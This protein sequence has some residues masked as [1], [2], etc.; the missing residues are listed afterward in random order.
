M[1][2]NLVAY[3]GFHFF[4]ACTEVNE[5]LAMKYL[6]KTD[7]IF[8]KFWKK[9]LRRLLTTHIQMRRYVEVRKIPERD[10]YHTYWRLHLPMLL[11]T[12][13]K[14]FFTEKYEYQ[15]YICRWKNCKKIILTCCSCSLG[16]W[17]YKGH[18]P[19]CVLEKVTGDNVTS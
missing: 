9:M 8:M 4:I 6:L 10:K 7:D 2:S 5:Y 16:T 15:K 17:L 1:G 12:I 11:N 18:N 13:K 14:R 3:P 19:M